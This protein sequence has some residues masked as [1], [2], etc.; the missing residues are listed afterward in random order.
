MTGQVAPKIAGLAVLA[1]ALFFFNP[2]ASAASNCNR[3]CL[4][5]QAKQFN[6]AMLAHTTEKIPLAAG[7]Q[8]RENTKAI[9]LTESRWMN[10]KQ[11]LSEGVY[12]DPVKGNVI[13]HVAGETADGKPV[14]IGTRLK[15]VD[16]K[17]KE[18]EI[19]FDDSAR[20]N[21]KNL[22]PYDPMFNTVVP[23]EERSSRE[24]LET[25][26]TRY[27]QG[28]TDHQPIKADYD[29]RCDRYH[30][31]NRVTHNPRNGVEASGDV[32]CYESNLGPK[33]WG[34][35]SEVRIGLIDPER[36]IVIGY[37]VLYYGDSPRRMQI[38]EIF[39]IL[40]GRIRMVDNIGL[41]EEGI[42]TS[43]FTQ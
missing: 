20:V 30:S 16:G 8:I 34:P 33:P 10:V 19:N 23:A 43:G 6:S 35:A 37:A 21:L 42:T 2:L 32:G 27:F 15:V 40:D 9:A 5:A 12:A 18:V 41:M 4:L 3:A 11:V 17:I 1:I 29:E 24:Q 28:L 38:N 7:A 13:E 14:Y 36:G 22:V 26:I 39:K 31:G 25:I